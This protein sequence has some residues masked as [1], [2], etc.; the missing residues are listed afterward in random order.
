MNEKIVK[1]WRGSR[2]AYNT[3]TN[4]DYW[5]RYTVTEPDGTKTEYFG[6]D[7]ISTDS[8]EL[9]PVEKILTSQEFL[10][11]T[12]SEKSQGKRYLV[13]ENDD[14]YVIEFGPSLSVASKIQPFGDNSVRVKS[15]K[16]KKYQL[17][18]GVLKTYDITGIDCGSR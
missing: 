1:F 4:F 11:L 18:D 10:S 7:K 5:T 17:V 3:L 16:Y 13:V 8:G 12:T 15:L 14:Y 2:N 6:T 9:Q